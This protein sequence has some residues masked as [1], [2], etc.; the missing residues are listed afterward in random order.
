MLFS[1]SFLCLVTNSSPK[2]LDNPPLKWE[3]EAYVYVY[4]NFQFPQP[5]EILNTETFWQA[6]VVNLLYEKF[7]F[8]EKV[9]D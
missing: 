1:N 2:I 4:W 8:V 6:L 3:T 9:N 7:G 5:K